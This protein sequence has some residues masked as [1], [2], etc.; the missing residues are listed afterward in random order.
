MRKIKY[1][2][3]SNIIAISFLLMAAVMFFYY[4]YFGFV[5]HMWQVDRNGFTNGRYCIFLIAILLAVLAYVSDR[6]ARRA[7]E[8]REYVVKNGKRFDGEVILL[9]DKYKSKRKRKKTWG[10]RLKVKYKD[11]SGEEQFT[12]TEW[13]IL[14][15]QKVKTP[16]PCILYVIDEIPKRYKVVSAKGKVF[17]DEWKLKR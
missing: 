13:Y 17:V 15:N 7:K 8:W 16:V 11:E 10:N 9:L 3:E 2:E 14:D 12:Q 6:F 5:L 1:K 4:Y